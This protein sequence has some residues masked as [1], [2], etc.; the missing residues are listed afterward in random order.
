MQLTLSIYW[1]PFN[2]FRVVERR[3][4]DS[5]DCSMFIDL[6]QDPVKLISSNG[7]RNAVG[8]YGREMQKVSPR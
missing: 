6:V 8:M 2:V 4:A 1:E 7:E 5:F 3:Y